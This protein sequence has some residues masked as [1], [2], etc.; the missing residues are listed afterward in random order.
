[1]SEH[2]EKAVE[3][4]AAE[5]RGGDTQLAHITPREV[6]MLLLA[7][8]QG[9][10]N[11][12]TGLLEFFDADAGAG[13]DGP[14]S[15]SDPSGGAGESGG[16]SGGPGDAG[17]GGGVDAEAEAAAAEASLG[18]AGTAAQDAQA[19]ENAAISFDI[20]NVPGDVLDD[21]ISTV[22]NT[23]STPVGV[24]IAAV[25]GGLTGIGIA[26][27]IDA[28]SNISVP[29]DP[30]SVETSGTSAGQ[31]SS[32]TAG[33]EFG[34]PEDQIIAETKTGEAVKDAENKQAEP[35]SIFDTLFN[36]ILS[37]QIFAFAPMPEFNIL[38]DDF[39]LNFGQGEGN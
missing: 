22:T 18:I 25:P 29:D 20:S 31:D 7:G 3:M 16:T 26:A 37:E 11:P 6:N 23:L 19:A 39:G 14:G 10:V 35:T 21:V 1:M 30:T 24:G 12:T 28:I 34:G 36:E 2:V 13:P 38:D 4:I 17:E 5:G 33:G 27:T 8:G 32:S 9:S 15:G